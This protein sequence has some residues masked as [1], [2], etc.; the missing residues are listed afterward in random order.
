MSRKKK[1]VATLKPAATAKVQSDQGRKSW[2]CFSG[3]QFY[4]LT[5]GECA[6]SVFQALMVAGLIIVFGGLEDSAMLIGSA[7]FLMILCFS[8]LNYSITRSPD[9]RR[10]VR[11]FRT[12][13]ALTLVIIHFVIQMASWAV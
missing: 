11:R 4:K 2:F 8:V 5:L 3:L 10:P 12:I 9:Y 13:A 7:D 1:G 6:A